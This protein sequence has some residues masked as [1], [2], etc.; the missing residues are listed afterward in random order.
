MITLDLWIVLRG[1]TAPQRCMALKAQTRI[2]TTIEDHPLL[3]ALSKAI[4]VKIASL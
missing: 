4:C 2:F 1:I 3:R